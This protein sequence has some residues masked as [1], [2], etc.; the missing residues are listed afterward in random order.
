[1]F[2]LCQEGLDT[3][4]VELWVFGFEVHHLLLVIAKLFH[5]FSDPLRLLFHLVQV[6]IKMQYKNRLHK[7]TTTRW[8]PPS[9]PSSPGAP[10]PAKP[11]AQFQ[12]QASSPVAAKKVLQGP[13]IRL[14]PKIEST[15]WSK[16]SAHLKIKVKGFSGFLRSS[17]Q[18]DHR[19]LGLRRSHLG[20][21]VSGWVGDL[22][23]GW[24]RPTK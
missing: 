23:G 9:C 8:W 20:G 11:L 1:M 6:Q 14:E 21:W 5:G 22:V 7:T 24:V 19:L 18:K 17:W 3:G 16:P 2:F 10:S 15:K 4:R 13:S 12:H